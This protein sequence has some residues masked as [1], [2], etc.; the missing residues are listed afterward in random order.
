[1][2]KNSE[3]LKYVTTHIVRESIDHS[4]VI[5]SP[6]FVNKTIFDIIKEKHEGHDKVL[7]PSR[8]NSLA[9]DVTHDKRKQIIF[10]T[11]KIISSNLTMKI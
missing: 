7:I 2:T 9:T 11:N 6:D 10:Y 3:T 8:T 1:M 4:K 5:Q